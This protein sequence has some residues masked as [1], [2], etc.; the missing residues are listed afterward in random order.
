MIVPGSFEE[1]FVSCELEGNV[2]EEIV[3]FALRANRFSDNH[4]LLN[5]E[6]IGINEGLAGVLGYFVDSLHRGLTTR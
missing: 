6:F 4:L 1:T 3:T 2:D 5:K